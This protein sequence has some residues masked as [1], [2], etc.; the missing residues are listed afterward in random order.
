[1]PILEDRLDHRLTAREL[2]GPCGELGERLLV[3]GARC[4]AR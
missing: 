2:K 4:A 1:M 3:A